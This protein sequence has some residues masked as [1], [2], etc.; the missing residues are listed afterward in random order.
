LRQRIEGCRFS[1]SKIK[2]LQRIKQVVCFVHIKITELEIPPDSQE[3]NS[4]HRRNARQVFSE[5]GTVLI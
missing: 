3:L 2:M 5:V 4:E 1:V